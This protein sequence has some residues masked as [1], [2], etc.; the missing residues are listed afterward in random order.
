M[1]T[2]H[3]YRSQCP[4]LLLHRP[5]VD[6]LVQDQV[7]PVAIQYVIEIGQPWVCEGQVGCTHVD[8]DL[9]CSTNLI[10]AEADDCGDG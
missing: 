9:R 8:E 2:D 5:R 1:P 4:A 6:G 10:V 7:T 3:R